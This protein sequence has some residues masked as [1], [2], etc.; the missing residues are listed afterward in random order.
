MPSLNNKYLPAVDS[1]KITQI[2]FGILLHRI[3][4]D[5]PLLE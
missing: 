1:K 4:T 5:E 3:N 2:N